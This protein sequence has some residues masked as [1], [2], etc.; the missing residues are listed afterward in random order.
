[1]LNLARFELDQLVSQESDREVVSILL[2]QDS[3]PARSPLI[4]E[5]RIK[6]E[7]IA[8]YKGVHVDDIDDVVNSGLEKL[9]TKLPNFHGKGPL[10]NWAT[11]LFG[12]HCIDYFR[13]RTIYMKVN[14][15][16]LP[17]NRMGEDDERDFDFDVFPGSAPDPQTCAADQ[18]RLAV[19]IAAIDKVISETAEL[20]RNPG[21][22]AEIARLG[23]KELCEPREILEKLAT[24]FPKL[25]L[26]AIRIVLHEF[27]ACLRVETEEAP[28]GK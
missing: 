23:L 20:R 15:Y 1:M 26:N 3:D 18:E 6:F 19:V 9:I 7:K 2:S 17:V 14:G 8:R 28:R 21:R 5:I 25:S 12:N 13:R 4:Q 27:R 10:N 11:V 22:D 16:P 24:E